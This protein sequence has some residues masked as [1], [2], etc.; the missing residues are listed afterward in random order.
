[1][2]RAGNVLAEV[3]TR[4]SGG[5][6]QRAALLAA[7]APPRAQAGSVQGDHNSGGDGAA[8]TA[9]SSDVTSETI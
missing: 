5:S 8:A 4:V 3:M 9:E 6:R 1:M 7:G 2:M